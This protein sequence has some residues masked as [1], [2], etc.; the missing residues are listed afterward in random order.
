MKKIILLMLII[1]SGIPVCY[2]SFKMEI[3]LVSSNGGSLSNDSIRFRNGQSVPNHPPLEEGCYGELGKN[4]VVYIYTDEYIDYTLFENGVNLDHA[5]RFHD[6]TYDDYMD[7]NGYRYILVGD[8]L[9]VEE[10]DDVRY[11]YVSFCKTKL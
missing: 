9:L 4:Y 6:Q 10:K 5:R 3:G 2:A 1:I 8:A 11:V 7:I